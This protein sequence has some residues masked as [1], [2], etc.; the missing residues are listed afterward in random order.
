MF[1]IEI[2]KSMAKLSIII[3]KLEHDFIP[4]SFT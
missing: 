3:C 2:T 4:N 1:D